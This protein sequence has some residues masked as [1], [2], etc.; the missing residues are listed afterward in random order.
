[1]ANYLVTGAA[2]FI[3]AS[4]DRHAAVRAAGAAA[5]RPGGGFGLYHLPDSDKRGIAE[6]VE[7]LAGPVR[8]QP[9]MTQIPQIGVSLCNL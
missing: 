6:A 3:G 1:M 9:Q 2:G 5:A 4:L 7:S 8:R